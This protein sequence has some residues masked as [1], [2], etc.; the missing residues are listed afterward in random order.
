MSLK[1]D[2]EPPAVFANIREYLFYVNLTAR[3]QTGAPVFAR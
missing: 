3:R 1:R 2:L